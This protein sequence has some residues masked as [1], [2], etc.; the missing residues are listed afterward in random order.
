MRGRI[1]EKERERGEGTRLDYLEGDGSRN[2]RSAVVNLAIKE[3]PADEGFN[4]NAFY[5][6]LLG[7]NFWE[8]R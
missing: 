1:D 6:Y 3:K 5:N 8:T 2:Y 4:S 7:N